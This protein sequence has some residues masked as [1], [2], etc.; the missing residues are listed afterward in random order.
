MS[1]FA[2]VLESVEKIAIDFVGLLEALLFLGLH[3]ALLIAWVAWWLR[4]VGWRKA[5]PVLARGGWA[6]LVLLMI[7]AAL[8]WS[9]LAPSTYDDLGFVR[10]GNFWWQL[11]AVSLLAGVTLLCGWLQGLFH[12]AP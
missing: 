6:P 8:V 2:P 11:G 4:A 7:V 12:W 10:I 1:P 9:R 5:W 3:F